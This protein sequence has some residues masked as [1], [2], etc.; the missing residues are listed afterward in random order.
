MEVREKMR[1]Y[2]KGLGLTVRQ[3]A[4]MCH[5]SETL[6]GMVENGYVTHPKIAARIQEK[7]GLTD[8]EA[9]ELVPVIHRPHGGGYDPERYVRDIDKKDHQEVNRM[10]Y[11]WEEKDNA[12][13]Q[14]ARS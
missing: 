12:E 11:R 7:Y 10:F 9:E 6:M 8:L 14:P 13:D 1:D 4:R 5:I 3:M 2:R